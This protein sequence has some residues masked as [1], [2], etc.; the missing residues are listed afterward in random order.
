MRRKTNFDT[1]L[2]GNMSTFYHYVERLTE[3]SISMFEWKNLPDEIDE[4]FLEMCLFSKGSAV[5]FKDEALGY[6][7]LNVAVNGGFNVYKIPIR[8][9]AYAVNGYQKDLTIEDSVIIY[10][11]MVRTNS[12]RIVRV[13]AHR[14][15]DL[16]RT[17]DVNAR[18]QKTPVVVQCNDQQRLTLVNLYKEV[19]GNSP[20]IFADK[21]LDINSALKA[22]Q[23]DAPYV[24][25]KLYQLKT[26]I[27][28]EALT[29]LGISNIS[30]QKKERLITDE[31]IRSMGGT[32]AS[33]YSRLESR[34]KA[35]REINKMFGLNIDVDFREDFRQTDD[36][37]ML[38]G[39]SGDDNPDAMVIDNRTTSSYPKVGGKRE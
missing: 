6:L 36:E 28:N 4:R 3:L 39:Q 13:F 10:N 20:V 35:C 7:A 27:W 34:R 14:L 9:R 33:R 23:T 18:A 1:S 19:D 2:R 37:F 30:V 11:N 5:F 8:R 25:D 31:A 22:I 38:E 29:Y 12:E 21:N 32:I 26:Q 15:W 17:I 24:G 16:D